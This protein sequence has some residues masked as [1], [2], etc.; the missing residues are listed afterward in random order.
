MADAKG[1]VELI[2]ARLGHARVR[3]ERVEARPGVDHPGR[4]AS[5]VADLPGERGSR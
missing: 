2:V 5:I 4:T 1:L 3:Y